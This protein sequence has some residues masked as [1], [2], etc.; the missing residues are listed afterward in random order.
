[1]GFKILFITTDQ[2][3]YDALGCNGGQIA[4]TPVIDGLAAQGLN[5]SRAYNQ[6]TVCMPAR[7]TMITGQYVRSHGVVMNGIPLPLDGPDAAATL[8]D[9]AGYRTALIGKAHFEPTSAPDQSYFENFAARENNTGPHRGF[10]R[11]ELAGH[12]GR[13]GRS[14]FHYPKWLAENH[15]DAVDGYFEYVTAKKEIS[16]RGGGDTSLAQLWHN[17]MPRE[18][19]H[20]DWVADRAIAWLDSLPEED[21][22]FLWMSFPDPHHPWD[23][24]ASE[25]HRCPWRD[26]DL[27][28]FYPGSPEKIVELLAQK[29][30]HWREWYEGRGQFNYEVPPLFRPNELTPDQIREVNAMVHISNELIDEACGKV[31]DRIDARSWGQDTD[32]FYTTDHGEMQGEFGLLFK[33]PYHVDA[34]MR[35]PMIWR[36]APSSGITPD[37]IEAPVGHLDLAPTFCQVAGIEPDA[38]MEGAALPRDSNSGRERALTEWD[39]EYLGNEIRLRSIYRDGY[40][41]TAYEKTN[42]YSGE[43]GELYDLN[44]DPLQWRNLWNDPVRAQL[45]SDLLADLHDSLPAPRPVPLK[46]VALV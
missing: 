7:S 34:L 17:E 46:A 9:K 45:R 37:A 27:P 12:T 4:R 20:T 5:Y 3:R 43:E 1:M 11:M 25:L 41:C 13:A 44:E 23:P 24:P 29:P 32:V 42:Y 14:L 33:G 39:S 26:L 2:Q 35:V 30:R 28:D 36:P 22:W 38:R 6:N 19:Y 31:L 18:L 16:S 21:D 15:P 10:E 8:R 40:V